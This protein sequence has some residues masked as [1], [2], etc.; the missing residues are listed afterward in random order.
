LFV[1][2]GQKAI[3]HL[4]FLHIFHQEKEVEMIGAVLKFIFGK[5]FAL[6]RRASV[7]SFLFVLP[8]S[9]F[10]AYPVPVSIEAEDCALSNGATVTTNVYGTAYPGYS[11]SGFVWVPN[12]GT[13]TFEVEVPKSAMY[14]LTARSWMYLG[15]V[16]DTRQQS[17]SV[18]GV[19]LGNFN[20]P[21]QG[22][23]KDFSF[24]FVYL[25]AGTVTVEIGSTGSWGFI[26]YDAVKFDYADMPELSI[27]ATP[28]DPN[29]TSE[30]RALMS[31]L[32]SVYGNHVISGQ[33]EIYGGGNNGDT[34][35]EFAYIFAKTGKYPAIRGFDLMN[36][37]PLYGWED[38]TTS[39]MIKWVQERKGIVTASWHINV[40]VDF[41]SYTLGEKL[42]WKNC[43]Y[44]PT[45]S[46]SVAKALDKTTKENAYL[47]LAIDS[48]AKQL[49]IL[50]EA[51]VPVLLRPFHEAEGNNNTDGSGAW[52]WWGS[53]GAEVYKQLWRLLYT[54]LTEKYGIHN[55]IWEVNLY[56]YGNSNKW[57]P[58]NDVVD[59]VAY[60]KYEGSPYTW[61]TSA[62]TT[63]FLTLVDA[64]KDTRMVAL[65]ENDVIPDIQKVV[66]EGAWWLYFC[67]W[68]G[69]FITSSTYNDPA[70]LNTIYNS[71][72]VITLDEIPENL[73]VYSSAHRVYPDKGFAPK[74]QNVRVLTI[75]DDNY[76]SEGSTS[77]Y[78][79]SGK[80]TATTPGSLPKGTYIEKPE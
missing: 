14:E 47:M 44:K 41:A 64:T 46:F 5:A 68:Y 54:T 39:R 51:K 20:I 73:Y 3:F 74:T 62:A 26:L 10:A 23:W 79:V 71:E 34:E 37:N 43:T 18:N 65:S 55:L 17:V 78:S 49:L 9:I 32:T 52:F 61:K 80:S 8:I 19:S 40:P 42:N 66:N 57:Y 75:L 31:Y 1:E 22:D 76:S 29:A 56:T 45:A 38:G 30:T 25:E 35:L 69:D 48:L 77:L 28:S 59:I 50:Q 58:G 63:A 16:G 11:G 53:A 67:P 60:D 70:L 24:G 33:Q 12:A 2:P 21:N 4:G 7:S 36:Y 72:H 6:P 13:L 15:N 27:D